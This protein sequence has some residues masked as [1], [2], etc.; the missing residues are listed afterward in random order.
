MYVI[1]QHTEMWHLHACYVSWLLARLENTTARQRL[2]VWSY[3]AVESPP[4]RTG[5]KT[6]CFAKVVRSPPQPFSN[7]RNEK[8]SNGA[9][10]DGSGSLKRALAEQI[11]G[12]QFWD[13]HLGKKLVVATSV[14]LALWE[15]ET[16]GL[17]GLAGHQ[18]NSRFSERPHLK[19][20]AHKW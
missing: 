8:M 7:S 2:A 4:I 17:L 12:H 9:W 20:V 18:P 16:E 15:A 3:T 13:H 19:G 10:K 5:N 1:F 14:T 6:T 11:W